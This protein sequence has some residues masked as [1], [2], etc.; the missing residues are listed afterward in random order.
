MFRLAFPYADTESERAEMAYLEARFDS[1]VANGGLIQPARNTRS[2]AKKEA[3]LPQG[4]TGVRLQGVWI[5]C[6]SASSI[7]EDYGLLEIVQPLLDATA[8]KVPGESTPVL[9]PDPE[10]VARAA[11]VTED[12][13]STPTRTS[14][15]VRMRQGEEETPRRVTRRQA[16]QNEVA[17]AMS[18]AQVDAQIRESQSLVREIAAHKEEEASEEKPSEEDN[19]EAG[20]DGN[21]AKDTTPTRARGSDSRSM[22]RTSGR[23]AAAG[24]RKRRL[25]DDEEEAPAASSTDTTTTQPPAN[26]VA[27]AASCRHSH[28]RLRRAAG[29]LAASA[30]GAAALYAGNGISISGAVSQLQNLDYTSALQAIQHNVASWNVASWLS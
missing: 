17:A 16:R 28:P 2:R 5:P 12:A 27:V 24:S 3:V 10:T 4:S 20:A 9:N 8:V 29:V 7:A 30:V 13:P 11:D 1:D 15:R 19:A 23:A 21:D 26:A 25:A 6:E 18:P 14:K 22:R